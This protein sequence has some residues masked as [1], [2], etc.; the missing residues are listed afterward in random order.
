MLLPIKKKKIEGERGDFNV[1]RGILEKLGGSRLI[2]S[3]R[4]FDGFIRERELINPLLRNASSTWSNIQD[5][6][7]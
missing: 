6:R 7:V 5:S 2:F 3:M 4:D 1:I